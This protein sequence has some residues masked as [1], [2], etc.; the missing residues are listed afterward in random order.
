[1]IRYSI[2]L[3]IILSVPFTSHGGWDFS[4]HSI[5][6]EQ[7]IAG[8]PPRDGIPALFHP[9]CLPADEA[10]FMQ[11]GE[12]VL[13]VVVNGIAR[14]YPDTMVLSLD[15][16]YDRNY[17]ADPYADY[18]KSRRI[19]FGFARSILQGHDAK[20]LIAGVRI[21]ENSK[22]Y[23]MADLR[24]HGTIT[25]RLGGLE[26]ALALDPQTDILSVTDKEGGDVPVTVTY[27]FVWKDIHPDSDRFQS[28]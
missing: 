4:R 15:T 12:Q 3:V 20:E 23:P 24:K 16:G 14:A 11:A 17:A 9:K 5:P 25:D 26:L 18:Y 27:W 1:M 2:L 28:D 10:G 22:A 13:G 6:P 8:G 19:L 21:A 7:I